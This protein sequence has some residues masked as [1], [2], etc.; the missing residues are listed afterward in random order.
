ML[1]L[2]EKAFEEHD[3]LDTEVAE[4]YHS[5]FDTYGIERSRYRMHA[6]RLGRI[7]CDVLDS[8]EPPKRDNKIN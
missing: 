6:I 3:H 4:D 1:S 8:M 7:I 5:V 2:A